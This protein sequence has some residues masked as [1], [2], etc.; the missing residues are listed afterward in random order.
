MKKISL[1]TG[2]QFSKL[3][4]SSIRQPDDGSASYQDI[5]L[6]HTWYEDGDNYRGLGVYKK[7]ISVLESKGKCLF[8][9]IEGADHTVRAYVNEIELG[10]HKGGYSRVRFAIPESCMNHTKLELKLYVDNSITDDV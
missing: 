1:N 9:E 7:T 3:P 4:G 5:C 6:P 8:L 10:I 2:W